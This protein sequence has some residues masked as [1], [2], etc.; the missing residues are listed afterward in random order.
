MLKK[1][2]VLLIPFLMIISCASSEEKLQNIKDYV[3]KLTA[4]IKFED[5]FNAIKVRGEKRSIF[6]SYYQNEDLVFINEDLDIGIR[7][8][9]ANKYFFRNGELVYFSE[10]TVLIK[11]DSLKI[12]GKTMIRSEIY[13]NGTMS[14]YSERIIK[15]ISVPFSELEIS[16]IVEHSKILKDLAEINKPVVKE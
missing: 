10:Q 7:G 2:I 9:S 8:K 13:F 3:A 15:G 6:R 11:D 5:G 12:N 14:L 1:S 4:E 16:S